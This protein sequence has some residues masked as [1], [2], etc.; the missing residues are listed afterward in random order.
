MKR[1]LSLLVLVFMFAV[2]SSCTTADDEG[3]DPIESAKSEDGN[4]GGGGQSGVLDDDD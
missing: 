2:A 1:L 3:F 4:V